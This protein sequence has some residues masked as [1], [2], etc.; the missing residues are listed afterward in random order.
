MPITMPAE[1]RTLVNNVRWETYVALADDRIGSVPRMTFD[2]GLL[3]LMSPRKEH[4]K[5]KTF[6]G[7][8]VA[9]FAEKHE[10]DLESV[11]STTFRRQDLDRGFEADESF[12]I[13]HA[14]AIR[15]KDDI[16][17]AIDPP[18]E[19]VIEVEITSSAIRK[20][21]LFATMGVAE[22]WR[23]DGKT[24]RLYRLQD[25]VYEESKTSTVLIGFP[26]V[27]AQSIVAQRH[28]RS[29]IELIKEFRAN[30]HPKQ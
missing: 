20:L 25:G 10:I 4:E 23:H 29:E 5:I 11:A 12:Y 13:Q 9:A 24:L 6:L 14:A 22:V 27:D 18:P 19:L 15:A 8:L 7:R 1:T 21:E 30:I 3:E 28:Q 17:L 26:V 16:D 2:Q